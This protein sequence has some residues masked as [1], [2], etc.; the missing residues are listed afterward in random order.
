MKS[1][2]RFTPRVSNVRNCRPVIDAAASCKA[3]RD[4][5]TLDAPQSVAFWPFARRRSPSIRSESSNFM[6][7]ISSGERNVSFRRYSAAVVP[8]LAGLGSCPSAAMPAQ[9]ASIR[10]VVGT[11]I[12][13]VSLIV[14]PPCRDSTWEKVRASVAASQLEYERKGGQSSGQTVDSARG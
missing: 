4:L 10:A 2:V 11:S 13:T 5:P 9:Q 14:R 8:G 1:H 6:P 12:I 3:R 7:R